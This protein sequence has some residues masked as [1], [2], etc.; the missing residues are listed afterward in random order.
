MRKPRRLESKAVRL[1]RFEAFKHRALLCEA[2]SASQ[3][4]GS[5]SSLMRQRALAKKLAKMS[6]E[7]NDAQQGQESESKESRWA[8]EC[9][10]MHTAKQSVWQPT[11]DIRYQGAGTGATSEGRGGEEVRGEGPGAQTGKSHFWC[12]RARTRD[13]AMGSSAGGEHTDRVGREFWGGN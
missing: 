4:G 12:C 1:V 11:R 7:A 6:Q 13:A 10:T 5:M 2:G 3:S 9:S 8:P